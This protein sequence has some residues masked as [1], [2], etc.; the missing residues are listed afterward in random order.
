MGGLLG[1]DG[2]AISACGR[3]A[4]LVAEIDDRIRF[5]KHFVI[6]GNVE[7][8]GLLPPICPHSRCEVTSDCLSFEFLL[9]TNK[10]VPRVCY[11]SF[12]NNADDSH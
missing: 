12:S 4:A 9:V 3:Y 1:Q 8:L 7:C 5:S 2:R 11:S 10:T 6:L